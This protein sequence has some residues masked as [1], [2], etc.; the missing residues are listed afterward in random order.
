MLSICI[1]IGL[2]EG[3]NRGVLYFKFLFFV[4]IGVLEIFYILIDLFS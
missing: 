2:G 1:Y 3:W 4:C